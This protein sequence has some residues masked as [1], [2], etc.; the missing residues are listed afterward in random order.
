[1]RNIVYKDMDR[2]ELDAA[3]NNT[4][5]I[6]NFPDLLND[7]RKKSSLFYETHICQRNISYGK[8]ERECYDYISCG[9]D[10]MATYVFIHG[11]YWS[12]CVKEDFAFIADVFLKNKM[13]VVLVEYT[14]APEAS[15]TEIVSQI[16][17]LLDHLAADRDRLGIS[18]L[19]LYI[20]GHSAGGHLAL[21][22]RAHP[23]VAKVHA[24]SALV[25][26]E[27]IGLCW[28]QDTL[29]LKPEEIE[30]YSPIL[31][32]GKGAPVLISVGANELIGLRNQST[33]YALA[34][35]DAGEAIALIHVPACTHF[36]MLE[37][38]ANPEGWQFKMFINLA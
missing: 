17:N 33:E 32:I 4:K 15:M 22:H 37:D 13:N 10:A 31:H 7:F 27:P 12:N 6:S 34:C 11:G 20:G 3:F 9:Q 18:D 28:L 2:A 5:A 16:G 38:L 1:M 26:L 36:S 24:I 14:L 19:P 35:E 25:D 8:K 23:S 29:N 21:I 30:R